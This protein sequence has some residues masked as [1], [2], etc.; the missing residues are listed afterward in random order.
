VV[1]KAAVSLWDVTR[2]ADFQPGQGALDPL[3]FLL[4]TAPLA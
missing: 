2:L 3:E 4:R 1:V